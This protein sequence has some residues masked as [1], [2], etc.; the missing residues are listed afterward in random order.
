[1]KFTY[2]VSWNN[3]SNRANNPIELDAIIRSLL[4]WGARPEDIKITIEL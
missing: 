3:Q 1:M 4:H 2:R